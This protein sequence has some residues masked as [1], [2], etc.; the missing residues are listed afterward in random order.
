MLQAK[1]AA[2][3]TAVGRKSVHVLRCLNFA[4]PDTGLVVFTGESGSGKTALLHLLA[5]IDKPSR[6]EILID[7]E[8]TAHWKENR[9]SAYRRECALTDD[10]L[11]S[12]DTTLFENMV[13]SCTLAGFRRREARSKA[14]EM[15]R[16]FSPDAFSDAY[17]RDLSSEQKKLAVLCFAIVREPSVLLADEPTDGLSS[18]NAEKILGILRKESSD[19]L[20]IVATRD[21]NLFNEDARIIEI[22]NGQIASDTDEDFSASANPHAP[23]AGVGVGECF[24]MALSNLHKPK[25]RAILRTLS[26]FSAA[27]LCTIFFAAFGGA[28]EKAESV[29][30]EILSA[31]PVTLTEESIPSGNLSS[32]ADWLDNRMDAD[33]ISV[34]RRYAITAKIYSADASA[35]S[36]TALNC[37]ENDTLWTQ[38]PEG[39]SLREA[40]YALV[41]GRW[42]ERY[43]E[44]V[45]LLNSAGQID[46][47]C[48][49]ALGL[50][51]ETNFNVSYTDLLRLSY[52]VLL[53]T[54]E[55][56]QNVDG[57]WGYMGTDEAVLSAQISA[58]Q[59]LNIVGIL[60]PKDNSSGG[61]G[62]LPSLSEWMVQTVL[63]SDIVQAQTASPDIDV[64]T[65]LPF[66]SAGVNTLDEA[67]QR[68]SLRS[69]V[70]G[71]TPS[72][73]VVMYESLT[74][75]SI[76]TEQV[77]DALLQTVSALTGDDLSRAFT[78][79]IASGV[80]TSSLENN[81]RAFGA[82]AAQTV[83]EL[84]L[85]ASSFSAREQLTAA[86]CDYSETVSY[87][88][89]AA[90]IVQPGEELLE[91]SSGM[92]HVG[93][94][95]AALA[96]VLLIVFVSASAVGAR[97]NEF[98]SLKILGMNKPQSI[99]GT[100]GILL[101]FLGSLFGSVLAFVLCRV[102]ESVGGITFSIPI[103]T[104]A[105]I[106]LAGTFAS[107]ISAVMAVLY[108]ASKR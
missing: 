83:S 39:E 78:D 54:D 2:F 81:L 1:N 77:Q 26:A 27:F 67:G 72:A 92:Y 11:L 6:G 105:L 42:P 57:T 73:Q 18:E 50:D 89:T 17:P 53:P 65:G 48:L 28:E 76:E 97:S 68:A 44:A 95:L 46:E 85:Y 101:G 55:Y 61:V 66:D 41:S 106:A 45:V 37:S 32:L 63:T 24:R 86:L 96:S 4:L 79:F 12:L 22:E 15:L 71:L 93:E 14:R 43:D 16:I 91:N 9:R 82:E 34:Q 31:Y 100:E 103:S 94:I 52:R 62:Y 20:V 70:V 19:R 30:A 58:A 5:L 80:S 60:R 84:R 51:K 107:W 49:R 25:S 87:S 40:R 21:R 69:Y 47:A 10:S 88:D 90:G 29:E 13:Q 59:R 98:F 56:I 7:G 99:A 35:D 38:L 3:E 104:V 33:S 74:G 75:T 36:R 8:N 23:I 64:L 108:T 102:I